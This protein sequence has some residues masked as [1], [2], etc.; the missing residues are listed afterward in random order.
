MKEKR[1]TKQILCGGLAFCGEEE[2]EM[3]HAYAPVSYTHLD[4]YKRQDMV[5]VNASKPICLDVEYIF[6]S[7]DGKHLKFLVLPLQEDGWLFQKE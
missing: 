2:M 4:V 6:L 3:L 5:R 7:A 1:K